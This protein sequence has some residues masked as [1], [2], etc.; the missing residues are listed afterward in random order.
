MKN[1]LQVSARDLQ[2][3]FAR[4][5]LAFFLAW[6]DLRVRYARSLIGPFW[7]SISILVTASALSFVMTG[8]FGGELRKAL[9]FVLMGIIIWSFLS[10][11]LIEACTTLISARNHLSGSPL[12]YGLMILSAIIR[13]AIVTAHHLVAFLVVALVMGIRPSLSMLMAI[14]GIVLVLTAVTGLVFVVACLTPRFRDMVPLIGMAMGIGAL[15]SPVYW[16]PETLV[17]N[18][19]IVLLNP[20]TYLLDVMRAPLINEPT[21]PH[22]WSRALA[23]AAVCLILGL[24]VFVLTRRRL[25]FWI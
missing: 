17:R 8:L 3:S 15:L 19:A 14:P 5:P 10:Q 12:P 21:L 2:D 22:A 7:V 20:I 13:N 25:P 18:K 4:L 16:R 1:A 24:G 9:P 6:Q 23:S 11:S